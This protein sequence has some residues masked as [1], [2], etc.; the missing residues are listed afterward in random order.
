[1][2]LKFVLILFFTLVITTFAQTK[3]V[4]GVVTGEYYNDVINELIEVPVIVYVDTRQN[5]YIKGGIR[6]LSASGCVEGKQLKKVI[7]TL[8]KS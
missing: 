4:D 8:E 1:M 6:F 5:F 3:T 7:S 2:K